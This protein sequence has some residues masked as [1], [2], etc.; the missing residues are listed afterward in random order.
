MY[1]VAVLFV[2]NEWGFVRMRKGPQK[3]INKK[4]RENR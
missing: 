4:S 2:V 1:I 3:F